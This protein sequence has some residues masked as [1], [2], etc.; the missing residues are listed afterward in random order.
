MGAVILKATA[1]RLP[2]EKTSEDSMRLE[3]GLAKLNPMIAETFDQ[4]RE[5]RLHA[6]NKLILDLE[7]SD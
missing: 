6:L 3:D 5:A 2:V 4:H 1:Q 7:I